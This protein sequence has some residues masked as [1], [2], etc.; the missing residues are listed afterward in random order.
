MDMVRASNRKHDDSV[1][2]RH[3]FLHAIPGNSTRRC[4]CVWLNGDGIQQISPPG[5]SFGMHDT[6]TPLLLAQR[7]NQF[8]S[9]FIH[10]RSH[11][12]HTHQT[13]ETEFHHWS[14]AACACICTAVLPACQCDGICTAVFYNY[15]RIIF[16][17]M[18]DR[19]MLGGWRCSYGCACITMSLCVD[20]STCH[21]LQVGQHQQKLLW[22]GAREE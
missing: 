14:F 2:W 15:A 16:P 10:S 12:H 1:W 21:R 6:V 13:S 17:S 22:C 5:P 11:L 18:A 7:I 3:H 9:G 4:W 20:G 19:N 8:S